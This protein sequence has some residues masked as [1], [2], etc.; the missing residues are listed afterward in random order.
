[1]SEQ[2]EQ[3]VQQAVTY[4]VQVESREHQVLWRDI[5]TVEVPPRT[6]RLTVVE[7]ALAEAG[8]HPSEDPIAVR[9][10]PAAAAEVLLLVADVPVEPRWKVADR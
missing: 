3:A 6:K 10:L 2:V 9:V 4:V 1:M 5:A 7:R 8:M